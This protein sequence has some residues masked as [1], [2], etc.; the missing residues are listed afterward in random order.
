MSPHRPVPR[1]AA[2]ALALFV[3][4]AGA[5]A[6]AAPA[7]DYL[8]IDANEGGSSGGHAAIRFGDATFHYQ[9]QPPGVLR[10]LR[11]RSA[12]FDR[13]YA[14]LEN[15]TIHVSRIPVSDETFALLRDGF[16]RRQLAETEHLRTLEALGRDRR[17][18]EAMRSGTGTL[19]V[20][21]AGLFFAGDVRVT[22]DGVAAPS[23][24][25]TE[26]A[27]LALHARVVATHG[28]AFLAERAQTLRRDLAT[29][30]PGAADGPAAAPLDADEIPAP[31]YG[32]AERWEDGV[33]AL[34]ALEA[35]RTAPPL[36]PEV[37]RVVAGAA[38]RAGERR[39]VEALARA[40]ERD[41]VRLVGSRRPDWGFP[42]LL[43][44][45]RLA[46]LEAT[47]AAGR[48]VVLDAFP[49][50]ATVVPQARLASHRDA[51]AALAAEARDQFEAARR[52]LPA[53]DTAFPEARFA[54]LESAANRL[55]ELRDA[56]DRGAD[57][58][59][60]AGPLL[61]S[62]AALVRPAPAGTDLR[63]ALR[64][65]AAREEAHAD[66][67][68]RLH[69]YDLVSRNCVS[70]IFR[71][72]DAS[73]AREV[74][75][76][77]AASVSG[78]SLRRLVRAES[79]ARLGGHVTTDGSLAFI[80]FLSARAV[81][82][83]YAVTERAR[84]LSRRRWQV[85]RMRERENAVRVALRESNTLTSTVYRRNPDDSL[86]LFF[87]DDAALPRPALGALNLLAGLA[88]SALGLVTLPRDGGA[89][90]GAGL[91]GAFFSLPELAFFNVRKGSFPYVAP[92]DRRRL[93]RDPP[94]Q[95]SAA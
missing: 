31:A 61:P 50:G 91:R 47:R 66:A 8:Y 56:L 6:A 86:F 30:D 88:G 1:L 2:S 60:H 95:R 75:A 55:A 58:R 36:R 41:L 83:T 94:A 34:L 73:L 29:L 71:T 65:A 18:L 84:V 3:V 76:E 90:L 24:A 51:V 93:A 40:L 52:R 48:W 67:V 7:V 82:A 74:R 15:R 70:E 45:A 69:G 25:G 79:V 78:G 27:L 4:V 39:R 14:L 13:H 59:V 35:L 12:R 16:A 17:L 57:L 43:G 63:D 11:E 32:F 54:A 22:A 38:L 21:G 81:N 44:M 87:T 85:A 9:H 80:P 19:P 42:L 20:R 72:I 62:R 33:A 89:T 10:L 23:G 92:A 77:S 53:P 5:P 37:V 64:A 49:P 26:R 28:P 46:A 68:R